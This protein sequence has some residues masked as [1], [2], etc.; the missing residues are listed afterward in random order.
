MQ[1]FT[2]RRNCHF[3]SL[4]LLQQPVNIVWLSPTVRDLFLWVKWY[5]TSKP[6]ASGKIV[7]YTWFSNLVE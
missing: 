6:L 5:S 7:V 4:V 2:K 3:K 1:K